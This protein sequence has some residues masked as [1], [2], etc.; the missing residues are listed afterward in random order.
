MVANVEQLVEALRNELQQYGEMLAL[1]EFQQRILC[2]RAS[3]S[4]TASIAHLN[5]QSVAIEAAR[6]NREVFQRQ[7]ACGL[8]CP[9]Q[10]SFQQLIPLFPKEYRPLLSALA[11]EI[12]ELLHR[13]RERAQQNHF[14]L[15]HS[16]ELMQ[17]FVSS[18]TSQTQA[19]LLIEEN[20]LPGTLEI[21][22]A[23]YL[24]LT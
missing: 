17:Q 7:L 13:V 11:Q 10:E 24:A 4:V 9:E 6:R 16:L 3:D 20:G 14:H 21:T 2:D 12:T 18:F 15:R 8:N 19:A 23:R 22:P 5:A 1:L